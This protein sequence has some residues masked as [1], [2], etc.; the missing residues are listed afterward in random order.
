MF[1]EGCGDGG[2]GMD[3]GVSIAGFEVHSILLGGLGGK[4][5]YLGC[6]IMMYE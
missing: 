2:T 5:F 3:G 1:V 6:F 4:G